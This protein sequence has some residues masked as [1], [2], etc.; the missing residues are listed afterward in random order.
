MRF[1]TQQK[2]VLASGNRGKVAEFQAL[3]RDCNIV[4]QSELGVVECEETGASFVEN[5]ILKARNAALQSGLPA[6]ADDSGLVV[7]VLDGAPGV[8]SARYA[9]VGA[10]DQDNINKLLRALGGVKDNQR[11]ARFVCVL[12]YMRHADDPCPII[13]QASWEGCIVDTALGE[14]GFGYDSVF[15]V[16]EQQCT[17]AQLS[18]EI[19]NTLSHRRQALTMLITLLKNNRI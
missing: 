17:A 1:L 7:D 19:K 2:I 3:L 18:P 16:A 12:V 6:L 9:G 13:A 11:T 10:T 8:I 14:N 15:W 5:A 4:P